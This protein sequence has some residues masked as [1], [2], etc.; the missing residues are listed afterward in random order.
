MTVPAQTP[1]TS[2]VGDG[3]TLVFAFAWRLDDADWMRV[4]LDGVAKVRALD[5][6][7]EGATVRFLIPPAVGV[8]IALA[9]RSPDVQA[10][11]LP[12]INSVRPQSLE[13]AYDLAVMAQ[14]ELRERLDRAVVSPFGEAGLSLPPL[15]SM[16]GKVL[17]VKN[18]QFMPLTPADSASAAAA[19]DLSNVPAF[20]GRAGLNINQRTILD[21]VP[22][23][24]VLAVL[25]G[26]NTVDLSPWIQTTLN[27]GGLIDTLGF[28]Y[29]AQG[30]SLNV[31][32]TRLTGSGLFR[33]PAVTPGGVAMFTL[34]AS[35]LSIDAGVV[36]DGASIMTAG[37]FHTG[38]VN[39]RAVDRAR[40][41]CAVRNFSF[42]GVVIGDNNG[43]WANGWV[44]IGAQVE[45]VGWTGIDG[46]GCAVLELNGSSV[47][48]TGYHAYDIQN[49]ALV[50]GGV[51][52][53]S[54]ATPPF[55]IYNLAGSLGGVEGGA[56]IYRDHNQRM[57][58]IGG[59]FEDNLNTATPYDMVM[60]GEHDLT[61]AEPQM[62]HWVCVVRNA[63]GAAFDATSNTT[64]QVTIYN[65]S[66]LG[67]V[68]ISKDRGGKI[69]NVTLKVTVLGGSIGISFT[70]PVIYGARTV[71]T[72]AGSANVVLSDASN[73]VQGMVVTA[74]TIPAGRKIISL[75]P[76]TG[77]AVLSSGVGVAAGTVAATVRGVLELSDINIDLQAYGTV[78]GVAVDDGIDGYVTYSNVN[79]AGDIS[80]TSSTDVYINP[81]AAP[82]SGITVTA[83]RKT[84][85]PKLLATWNSYAPA[86][87]AAGGV[88]PTFANVDG[89]WSYGPDKTVSLS[90]SFDITAVGSGT[91]FL[92]IPTPAAFPGRSGKRTGVLF[93]SVGGGA[94]YQAYLL[95]GG[96]QVYSLGGGYPPLLNSNFIVTVTYEAG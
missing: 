29:L 10:K 38:V 39:D 54:K 76:A 43:A 44:R 42:K 11:A 30:L 78:Y 80:T 1:V 70:T 3:A 7:I 36:L 23:V 89:R 19:W 31:P 50:V 60:L 87:V 52:R 79:I 96:I 16:E 66:P 94:A 49:N 4:T 91:G 41:D 67:T 35:N 84:A 5:Y 64:G 21:D 17:A 48:R 28:T 90:I 24:H 9:R 73:L 12:N 65:A 25:A 20:L 40:I 6:V 2:T 68:L 71:T 22:A 93:Q 77:A 82:P 13:Q 37:A 27:R 51:M 34:A 81:S 45:N 26:T 61:L 74:A 58:M 72:T 62:E 46:Y 69:D 32:G 75:N 83:K 57:V 8:K 59:T 18:G 15:A 14:Q 85:S 88:S 55:R 92:Y 95:D 63:S 47:S 53:S 86:I 56:G 33:L